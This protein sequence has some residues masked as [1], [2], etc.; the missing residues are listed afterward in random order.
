MERVEEEVEIDAPVAVVY[1]QWIQ[2]EEFPEFM[3]GVTDVRQLD[4]QRLY[5]SAEILGQEFDWDTEICEH[6]PE[7]RIKWRSTSGRPIT[8]GVYFTPAGEK[9]RVR[10]V[11]ECEPASFGEKTTDV[12]AFFHRRLAANL[13][14]FREMLERRGRDSGGWDGPV[15]VTRIR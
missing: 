3:E 9:T 4:D 12:L 15:N 5:W 11:F 13:Q 14:S 2:F 6:V 8:G 10:L 7:T 1:N